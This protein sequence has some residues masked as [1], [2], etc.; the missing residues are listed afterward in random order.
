MSWLTVEILDRVLPERVHRN[1]PRAIHSSGVWAFTGT[2]GTKRHKQ[3]NKDISRLS[4]L[5]T[6]L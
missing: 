4:L 5:D 2:D 1:N 3:I 6:I